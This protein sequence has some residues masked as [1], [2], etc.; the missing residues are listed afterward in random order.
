MGIIRES[1]IVNAGAFI[2]VFVFLANLDSLIPAGVVGGGGGD[3]FGGGVV[4]AA[5]MPQ[6]FTANNAYSFQ[7]GGLRSGYGSPRSRSGYAA[8]GRGRGGG[9]GGG[10]SYANAVVDEQFAHEFLAQFGYIP[11]EGANST[12]ANSV[13][14]E[15]SITKFQRVAGIPQTGYLDKVTKTWMKRP[16]FVG[17]LT[18]C[19]WMKRFIY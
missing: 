6:R 19:R 9:G 1:A 16:R 17:F 2:F 10:R 14:I 18:D 3:F 15:T 11:K 8:S 7:R 12:R 4:A 5:P 13:S